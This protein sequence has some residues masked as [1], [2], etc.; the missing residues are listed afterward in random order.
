MKTF[1]KSNLNDIEQKMLDRNSLENNKTI[2]CIQLHLKKHVGLRDYTNNTPTKL[3]KILVY[4]FQIG[5][6]VHH[7]KV[8]E[9]FEGIIINVFSFLSVLIMILTLL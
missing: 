9:N 8:S 6:K 2:E 4:Y 7:M 3:H 5:M 1:S